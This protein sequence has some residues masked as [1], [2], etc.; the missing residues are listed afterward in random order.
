MPYTQVYK[1]RYLDGSVGFLTERANVLVPGFSNVL[2]NSPGY[3]GG[4]DNLDI[5]EHEGLIHQVHAF[6]QYVE[7][8]FFEAPLYTHEES[9]SN[10]K[11]AITIG[12]LIGTSFK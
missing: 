2:L 4:I 8:G 1:A 7:K 5:P 10:I 9:L 12:E 6:A 3:I 11:T